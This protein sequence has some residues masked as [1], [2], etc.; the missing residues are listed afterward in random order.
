MCKKVTHTG[1]GFKGLI[2]RLLES[3]EKIEQVD[4]RADVPQWGIL[5][6]QSINHAAFAE[7]SYQRSLE[8]FVKQRAAYYGHNSVRL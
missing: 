8:V 6:D 3:L 5:F 4:F 7:P 1:N 2:H